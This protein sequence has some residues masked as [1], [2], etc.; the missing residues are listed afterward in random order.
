LLCLFQKL[1]EKEPGLDRGEDVPIV[2]EHWF[3][4]IGIKVL[5]ELGI[6]TIEN[7]K[8]MEGQIRFVTA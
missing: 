8:L 5:E 4:A 7:P 3:M 1:S 6:R 2:A